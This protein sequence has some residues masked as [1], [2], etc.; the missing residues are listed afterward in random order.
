MMFQLLTMIIPS[1][2]SKKMRFLKYHI[3]AAVLFGLLYWFEDNIVNDFP[4]I[5]SEYGF[6]QSVDRPDGFFYWMWFSILTQTTV[7]YSGAVGSDGSQVPFNKITNNVYKIINT[8]QLLS[9]FFIT[10]QFV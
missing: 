5:F 9:I 8:L 10:S 3:G 1:N 4:K 6:G 7:G 2:S